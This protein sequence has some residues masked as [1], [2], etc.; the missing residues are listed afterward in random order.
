MD[1]DSLIV[2]EYMVTKGN[3]HDSKVAHGLIDSLRNFPYILAD[4]AYD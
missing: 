4:P 2:M 1:V 3:L